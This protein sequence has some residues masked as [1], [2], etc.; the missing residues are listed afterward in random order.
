VT[1]DDVSCFG[2]LLT[3]IEQARSLRFGICVGTPGDDGGVVT[4]FTLT[5]GAR[6]ACRQRSNEH[7]RVAISVS[8]A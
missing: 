5:T 3:M 4:P 2:R 8:P 7:G 1:G 6:A